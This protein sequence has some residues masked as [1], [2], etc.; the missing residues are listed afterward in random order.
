[1]KI[2]LN[3]LSIVGETMAGPSIRYWEFAQSLSKKHEVI[4][5]IPNDCNLTT[6]NFTIIKKTASYRK[7]FKE[8]D[9]IITM[10]ITHAMAWAA[11]MYGVKLIFDAYGPL[12]ME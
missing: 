1:M 2:L 4:L 7:L 6:N 8:V 10:V 5:L 9:V 11:K 3:C 12:P